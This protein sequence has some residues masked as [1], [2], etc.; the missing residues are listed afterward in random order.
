MWCVMLLGH[1]S[2]LKLLCNE[3]EQLSCLRFK[4]RSSELRTH[5]GTESQWPRF[6]ACITF[7]CLLQVKVPRSHASRLFI[8]DAWMG[9]TRFI[10]LFREFIQERVLVSS[11]MFIQLKWSGYEYFIRFDFRFFARTFFETTR[12]T[13][14]FSF[15]RYVFHVLRKKIESAKPFLMRAGLLSTSTVEFLLRSDSIFGQLYQKRGNK[16]RRR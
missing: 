12:F 11:L 9:E 6:I 16:I 7:Y 4:A 1:K 15:F 2:L 13:E 8:L 10:Y 14:S 5:I 3:S